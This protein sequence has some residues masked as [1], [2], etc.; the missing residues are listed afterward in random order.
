MEDEVGE[1]TKLGLP[2]PVSQC[3]AISPGLRLGPQPWASFR[4]LQG[5]PGV[6]GWDRGTAKLAA[7]S[8][9]WAPSCRGDLRRRQ[10]LGKV[11]E[12]RARGRGGRQRR[13][14]LREL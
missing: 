3:P 2:Y 1:E 5:A 11:S 8:L 13:S 4:F 10:G 14:Q 7:R 12:E 6:R 9:Q